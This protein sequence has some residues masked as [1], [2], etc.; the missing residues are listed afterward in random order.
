MKAFIHR[1]DRW[2]PERI[3][4]GDC[5]KAVNKKILKAYAGVPGSPQRAP[6]VKDETR[7]SGGTRDEG[8]KQTIRSI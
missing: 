6:A 5:M 8:M 7:Q 3:C 2:M 4:G 1:S